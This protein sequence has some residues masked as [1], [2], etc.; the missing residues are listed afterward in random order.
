MWRLGIDSI[1]RGGCSLVD[2]QELEER[3]YMLRPLVPSVVWFARVIAPIQETFFYVITAS[4]LGYSSSQDMSVISILLGYFCTE[5]FLAS[6]FGLVSSS[7]G[8]ITLPQE[9][10]EMI[11]SELDWKDVLRVRTVSASVIDSRSFLTL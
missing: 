8:I 5:G 6:C 10:L 7:C 2:V 3:I 4:A 9:V 11:L 1:V